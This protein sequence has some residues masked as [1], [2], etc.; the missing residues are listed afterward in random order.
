MVCETMLRADNRSIFFSLQ[1]E[2]HAMFTSGMEL[3]EARSEYLKTNGCDHSGKLLTKKELLYTRPATS[4]DI[5][6][7]SVFLCP[8]WLQA[9]FFQT[10]KMGGLFFRHREPSSFGEACD[11]STRPFF[12]F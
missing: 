2:Y 9:V 12:V 8:I 5:S 7:H 1:K 6:V 3:M 10:K 4:G 11:V